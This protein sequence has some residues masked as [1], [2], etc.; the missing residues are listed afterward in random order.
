MRHKRRKRKGEEMLQKYSLKTLDNNI[1]FTSTPT[2]KEAK[3]SPT[4]HLQLRYTLHLGDEYDFISL[5]VE[6]RIR[7][8]LSEEQWKNKSVALKKACIHIVDGFYN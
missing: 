2:T 5:V 1:T 6:R 4:Y 3:L 8:I 7:H